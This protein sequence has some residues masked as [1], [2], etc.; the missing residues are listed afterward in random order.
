MMRRKNKLEWVARLDLMVR[1]MRRA[2]TKVPEVTKIYLRTSGFVINIYLVG[3]DKNEKVVS[4][5]IPR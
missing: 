5:G 1:T 4:F 3:Y 2:M